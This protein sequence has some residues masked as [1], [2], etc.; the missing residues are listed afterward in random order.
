M[1]EELDKTLKDLSQALKQNGQVTY[2]TKEEVSKRVDGL[3]EIIT[4]TIRENLLRFIKEIPVNENTPQEDYP[5]LVNKVKDKFY[6][7]VINNL[8]HTKE[9]EIKIYDSFFVQCAKY[10]ERC[11]RIYDWY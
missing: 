4:K 11:Y 5:K 2:L 8:K 7:A 1:S 6:N 3:L 10:E 9:I